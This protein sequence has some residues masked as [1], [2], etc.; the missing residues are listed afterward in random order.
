MKKRLLPVFIAGLI[1]LMTAC[2]GGNSS[3][4]APKEE[5][6]SESVQE[7]NAEEVVEESSEE[8]AEE[9]S[10]PEEEAVEAVIDA[11]PAGS[12]TSFAIISGGDYIDVNLVDMVTELTLNEGGTGTLTSG[13]EDEEITWEV[14]GDKGDRIVIKEGMMEFFGPYENG[15]LEINL[16]VNTDMLFA[17]ETAD[18]SSYNL[19]TTEEEFQKQ[20]EEQRI[21]GEESLQNI[22]KKYG[23]KNDDTHFVIN[24]LGMIICFEMDGD[25][26]TGSKAYVDCFT[27][28]QAGLR[29][30]QYDRYSLY[31]SVEVD[32]TIVIIDMGDGM[33]RDVLDKLYS[34]KKID[35]Q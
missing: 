3:A 30:E 21:R 34:D 29:K 11:N 13:G 15:I 4:E 6:S 25:I 8:V 9:V 27:E 2:G 28:R 12:Y 10:E 23:L 32:G 16:L 35:P 7:E 33:T 14:E 19:I 31:D 24:N 1:L 26:S 5:T 20:Q 22:L 17:K 18:I